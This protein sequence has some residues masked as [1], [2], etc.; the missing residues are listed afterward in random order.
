LLLEVAFAI[1][2]RQKSI[3]ATMS[4]SENDSPT[5]TRGFAFWRIISIVSVFLWLVPELG[6]RTMT[7]QRPDNRLVRA[8]Q[9]SSRGAD[10]V[11]RARFRDAETLFCEAIDHC[12]TDERAHWGYATTLWENGQRSQ[13]INHMREA[14]RLSGN[15]PE[16]TVRLGEMYL[17]VGELGLAE[18]LAQQ[19][20]PM[21]RDQA[22]A[23]AL[24]G[25]C[26]V[27][28]GQ[29]EE[30]ISSYHRALLLRPDFPRVQIAVAETYRTAGKPNRAL[31]TLD[32]MVDIHPSQ[33]NVGETQLVR[34]MALIDLNRRDE[35][36]VALRAVGDSIPM[37]ATERQ[38]ALVHCYCQL[39]ELVDA[40][41]S[42]GR[43]L[44]HFPDDSAALA[45]QSRLNRSFEQLA[46]LEAP[47]RQLR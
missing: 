38:L 43:Y 35:A 5:R 28:H 47:D 14:V 22:D 37:E 25:D 40:R 21:H 34:A 17:A 9:L 36:L 13:A 19:I 29:T 23:W 42:L 1:A 30:A 39:G 10:L 18:S 8:R 27:R 16:Y 7:G 46:E 11:R 24:L 12:P 44:Q 45:I 4:L 41:I 26:Q 20:L 33:C 32:R 3:A 15:N 6:C 2:L 31:A